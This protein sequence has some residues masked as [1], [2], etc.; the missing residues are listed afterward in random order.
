MYRL[1]GIGLLLAWLSSLPSAGA[2]TLTSLPSKVAY[3]ARS[4]DIPETGISVWVQGVDDPAPLLSVNADVPRNP[5]STLKLVTTYAVLAQLGPAYTWRTEVYLDAP[6]R[7]GLVDGDLWIRGYGDPFFVSE[8]YWKL[9]EGL[10]NRGIGRIEGDLVFDSSFFDLPPEDSGAFDNQPDRVY[11]LVPHPLLVNFNAVRFRV[12]P[13]GDGRSVSVSTYPTLP[14]L[15]L[16]NRLSLYQSPCRGYQRGVALAVPDA[17]RDQ[18]FLEGKFPSGCNY[19]EMTRTVLQ[20][21]SYAYGLF[22]LY[23]RQLGGELKGGWRVGELPESA[24]EPFHIHRSQPLGDLIR[25]VNKYSNNVMTRNFELTLGAEMFGAPATPE[26]GNRAL[27]EVLAAQGVTTEGLVI[28]NSS[29]LAR[30]TR[31]SAH[32]LAE[33]LSAGWRSPYMPEFVSSLSVAGLDGTTRRRFQGTPTQ[34]RMHLKTG[35]LDNVSGIAG[36][37]TAESGRRLFVV[38]LV[39]AADAHRGPGKQLQNAV[40]DWVYRL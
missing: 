19:Y 14:N 36:Y 10:H 6:P 3:A 34:G 17:Q 15:Q 37:V 7:D 9:V 32:Q 40:L 4:L 21:E 11:N 23:W 26:K 25:K 31:I 16:R 22:D 1:I 35:R 13:G 33:V 5:A 38:V 8:E 28:S 12:Q 39:N 30:D 27:M 24:E 18:V 20:P 2:E 29:G